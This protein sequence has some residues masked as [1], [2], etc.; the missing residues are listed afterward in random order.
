MPTIRSIDVIKATLLTPATTSHFD[1]EIGL[2]NGSVGSKLTNLLGGSVQK[3]RLHIMCSDVSL[4]GSSLATLEHTN[5]RHGVTEKHAYRRIFE[6][7]ID[8]TFY[9]DA[10]GYLPIKFF[11]TWM[12][13]IMN[14]DS[15]DA[16]DK[17]YFYRSKYPDEYMADQGL[18]VIKFERDHNRSIEYEFFR[19][20]HWLLIQ[21]QLLMMHP[22]S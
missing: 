5:D 12:S 9:V 13:E 4:P 16:R 20:F 18:K 15:D 6:D 8:L 22:P 19:T 14:E 3:D 1:V 17:S 2:P 7:R 11:E 21:C 10:N